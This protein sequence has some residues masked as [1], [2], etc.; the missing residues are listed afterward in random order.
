MKLY[1]FAAILIVGGIS[2][3]PNSE[4]IVSGIVCILIGVGIIIIKR[5]I[6]KRNEEEQTI[7]AQSQPIQ[8]QGVRSQSATKTNAFDPAFDEHYRKYEQF[9]RVQKRYE[10]IVKRHYELIEQIGVAYT[11]ANNLKMPNSP[12]M[13]RVISLC[14]EDISLAV[15]FKKYWEE[16]GKTGY[17]ESAYENL[18]EYPA[19]KRLAIIYDKQKEYD[20]AIAVCQQ[21]IN[22]GY[23]RDGTD[24]QMP[25][26]LARLMRKAGDVKKKIPASKSVETEFKEETAE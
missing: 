15:A 10:N 2:T 26:R 23:V 19:F 8:I 11:I 5:L 7:Q 6:K 25:G 20:K 17:Y 24:G 1:I 18:P 16:L 3:L 4:N 21:A 22:L 14:E 13:D 9:E 12:E